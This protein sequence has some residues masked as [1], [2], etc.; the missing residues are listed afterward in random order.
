MRKGWRA[1]S[2]KVAEMA[3]TTAGDQHSVL[4]MDGTE[5]IKNIVICIGNVNSIT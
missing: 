1:A 5:A 2:A 4:S 3:A